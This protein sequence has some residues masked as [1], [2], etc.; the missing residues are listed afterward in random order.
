[1]G[2]EGGGEGTGFFCNMEWRK[3]RT[4]FSENTEW[5]KTQTGLRL[6]PGMGAK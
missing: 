5:G 6:N 2:G 4:G 1:M 3:T